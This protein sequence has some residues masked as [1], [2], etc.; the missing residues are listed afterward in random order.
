MFNYFF[1]LINLIFF[2]KEIKLSN[3]IS[4]PIYKSSPSNS[5][6]FSEFIDINIFTKIK[7]G[8]NLENINLSLSYELESMIIRE[9]FRP[10]SSIISQYIGSYLYRNKYIVTYKSND[11]LFL[12]VSNLKKNFE[13]KKDL[14]IEEYIYQS[15]AKY[16]NLKINKINFLGLSSIIPKMGISSNLIKELKKKKLIDSYDFSIEFFDDNN[17]RLILGGMPH[18]Y[19]SKYEEKYFIYEQIKFKDWHLTFNNISHEKNNEY[20]INKEGN[21]TLSYYG[22]VSS[23]SYQQLID[24]IFFNIL[25]E[26]N[27]CE[28]KFNIGEEK[29]IVYVCD[30]GINI[31]KFPKISFKDE[32][33]NFTFVFEGKELFRKISNNKLIFL[34]HFGN[35][36][37]IWK[38]GEIFI[39]KYQLVYNY[40]KKIIGLY[41]QK[42]EKSY[43][44]YFIYFIL[45]LI[46][47]ILLY[48]LIMNR[49]KVFRKIRAN[50]LEDSYDYLPNEKLT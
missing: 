19:D 36:E 7:I 24:K 47:I 25:F 4:M 11:T 15:L 31:K 37:N 5:N 1:Y 20:L 26:E 10:N 34:I 13:E 46:I 28:K 30:D 41:S 40:D 14:S 38:L 9:E 27:K 39:K 42:L 48:F 50:E 16:N 23:S 12:Q 18:E 44:H 45:I 17:G 35:D 3:I 6:E 29:V 49:K 32:L 21:L 43:I 2:I 22:L 33:I 8:N